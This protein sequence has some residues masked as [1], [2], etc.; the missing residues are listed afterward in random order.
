MLNTVVAL[1]L[2][3]PLPSSPPSSPL[4]S[5]P[6]SLLPSLQLSVSILAVVASSC[7]FAFFQLLLLQSY[8]PAVPTIATTTTHQTSIFSRQ[9]AITL[10]S[11][12]RHHHSRSSTTVILSTT[13]VL[14]STAIVLSSTTVILSSTAIVLSCHPHYYYQYHLSNQ[15]SLSPPLLISLLLPSSFLILVILAIASGSGMESL[16]HPESGNS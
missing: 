7:S 11:Y 9:P 15:H 16:A 8:C 13:V 12:Y 6:P 1:S 10:A 14:S 3:S 4:S 5:L 2:S